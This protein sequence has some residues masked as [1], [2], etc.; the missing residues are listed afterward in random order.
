MAVTFNH[1]GG[2]LLYGKDDFAIPFPL[3]CMRPILSNNGS[4]QLSK[5]LG[6]QNGR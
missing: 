6:R 5:A 3:E 2:V 4:T 1:D